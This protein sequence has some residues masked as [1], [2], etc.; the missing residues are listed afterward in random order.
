LC[1]VASGF[2]RK[3]RIYFTQVKQNHHYMY[4]VP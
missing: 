4:I 3:W 2:E 1:V